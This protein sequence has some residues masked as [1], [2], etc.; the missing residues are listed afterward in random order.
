MKTKNSILIWKNKIHFEQLTQLQ[1]SETH[2]SVAFW[3]DFVFKYWLFFVV[4]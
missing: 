4:N 3:L 2:I 1:T